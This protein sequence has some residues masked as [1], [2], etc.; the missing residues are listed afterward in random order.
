MQKSIVVNSIVV[1][2][3]MNP[4]YPLI[5]TAV[6]AMLVVGTVLMTPDIAF[7]EKK[8]E[9]T[10]TSYQ[11]NSCGNGEMSMKVFCQNLISQIQGDGNAINIIGLQ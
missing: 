4:K 1:N 8:Y 10:Q 2:R 7:A 9:K 11:S 3:S 5:I 6:T